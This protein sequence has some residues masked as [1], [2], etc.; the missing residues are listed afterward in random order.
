MNLLAHERSQNMRTFM[1]IAL[2]ALLLAASTGVGMRFWFFTA[3]PEWAQ[4]FGAI[5]HAHSHLMYFGWGTLAL[6]ALIWQQL[7]RWTNR[8]LG[9]AVRWQMMMTAVVALL[10]Y[11]A[12]WSN[13]YG[14]TQVGSLALP[15]GSIVSGWNG[16][17]WFFFAV[18]YVRATRHLSTRPLPVQLWDGALLLLLLACGG[19][20]GVVAMVAL[21]V[22]SF[23]LQQTFLHLFLELF[24]TGWFSLA[25]LGLLW[26]WIGQHVSLPQ[27]LPTLSLVLALAPTF[28]LGVSPALVPVHIFWISAGA[29]AIAATLLAWHLAALWRKRHYL[30]ILA[31]WG[32]MALLVHLLISW[33]L[34]WP[35]L[36]EWSASTQLRVFYLHNFLLGWVSSAVLGLAI[37]QWFAVNSAWRV[38][39]QITWLAGILL[40]LFALLNLGFSGRIALLPAL[41]WMKIA[42]WSSVVVALAIGMAFVCAYCSASAGAKRIVSWMGALFANA[43]Q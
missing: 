40:M 43:I 24:A 27:K 14:V 21:D 32:L 9:R 20:M 15:L 13:G 28:F 10:S 35:G 37:A 12:F 11:P 2:G 22:S 19:A 1:Q 18:L 36:W 23:F 6:M 39:I 25:L 17:A 30:P 8:A 31:Q 33:I 26:S 4:N 29:N 41:A 7:P 42:A 34:L 5:R 38:A 3:A 16:F